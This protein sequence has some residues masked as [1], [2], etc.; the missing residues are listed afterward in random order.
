[1]QRFPGWIV[2]GRIEVALLNRVERAGSSDDL[3]ADR[4][5][6]LLLDR[7]RL[8]LGPVNLLRTYGGGEHSSYQRGH[9]ESISIFPA[10]SLSPA[11]CSSKLTSC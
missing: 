11:N 3:A 7:H 8:K 9:R 4:E 6:P 1:M 5:A 2:A 10:H